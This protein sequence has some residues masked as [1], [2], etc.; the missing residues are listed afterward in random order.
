MNRIILIGN[1]FD[2]AHKLPTSFQNFLDNYWKKLIDQ[3]KLTQP[4][5][6]FQNDDLFIEK[7][8]EIWEEGTTFETFQNTFKNYTHK[9]I[10]KNKFLKTI[11]NQSLV[12]NWVDIEN[13]Y[14]ILLKR[15]FQ[16]DAPNYNISD[17]NKDFHKIKD[18]L[19]NYIADIVNNLEFIDESIKSQIGY[20][21]YSRFSYVDFTENA[22]NKRAQIEFD[23]LSKEIQKLEEDKISPNQLSE[24]RQNLINRLRGS[25]E[26]YLNL[27]KLLL[28]QTAPNYFDLYPEN[29]LFLNFNYTKV[30]KFYQPSSQFDNYENINPQPKSIQIHGS[31][32]KQDYNPIIFG[33]GDEIDEYYKSIENLNDNRYLEHIKSIKYLETDNYKRL[34]DF[35]NSD[36]Y[37]IFIFGHSCG[38]SDRTLLNTLFEHKNCVSIKPFY[39]KKGENQ[40]NYGELTM[41]ITRNFNDKASL[42]DKVVNKRFCEPLLLF[43]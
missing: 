1:G 25:E 35:I 43:K 24:G 14:Y 17:L 28:S 15:S 31:V 34:L 5:T 26:I 4:Y 40:D 36:E 7:A 13:E 16:E 29:V 38:N 8:P 22:I 10:Y 27:R 2:L 9:I 39:H 23:I 30:D 19:E 41:N 3:I 11:S 42:R 12:N 20:K 18:A 32:Y 6:V 21:I 37:Q 33:F